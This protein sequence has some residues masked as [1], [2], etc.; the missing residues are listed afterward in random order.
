[1]QMDIT[2]ALGLIFGMI[3]V[4]IAIY[5]QA[6]IRAGERRK[7]E[8]IQEGEKQRGRMQY[9]LAGINNSALQKQLAWNNRISTLPSKLETDKDWEL[10]NT[11]MR[12]RDAFSEI[13]SLTV[14]LEG[15]IDSEISA[16]QD[17]LQRSIDMT[18][19]NNELQTE[20]LKNP[21]R[22]KTDTQ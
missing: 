2:G 20:A 13:A 18:K 9:A 5:Q 3:S 8:M 21:T 10:A 7:C 22:P 6:V 12:G 17:M 4:C 14:A 11:L 15:T 19:L 16:I 1:M